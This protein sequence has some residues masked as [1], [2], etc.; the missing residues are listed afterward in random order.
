MILGFRFLY[1]MRMAGSAV[2]GVSNVS[3]WKF[4]ILNFAGAL[5]WA[6]LVA[7]AGYYLGKTLEAVL[8]EI[9]EYEKWVLSGLIILAVLIG[10]R[11]LWQLRRTRAA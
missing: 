9:I 4:T 2:L 10:S 7:T 11:K 6:G 1:G 8:G 3:T 5:L